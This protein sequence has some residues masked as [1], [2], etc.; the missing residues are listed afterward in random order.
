MNHLASVRAGVSRVAIS[1]IRSLINAVIVIRQTLHFLIFL[2]TVSL[3]IRALVHLKVN[4][5]S[6]VH[7]KLNARYI[8]S[9]AA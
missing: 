6:D 2:L 5:C 4:T 7:L 3:Y 8:C 1:Y 9:N